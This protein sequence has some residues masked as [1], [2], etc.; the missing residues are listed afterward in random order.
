LKNGIEILDDAMLIVEKVSDNL[1][2]GA[3]RKF[4]T[5]FISSMNILLLLLLLLL[6]NKVHII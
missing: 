2:K 6:L 3:K 1:G 5:K 4:F